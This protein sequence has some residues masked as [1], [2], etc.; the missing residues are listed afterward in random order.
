MSSITFQA[1]KREAFLIRNLMPA[2]CIEIIEK[3]FGKR[4]WKMK[5]STLTRM[6]GEMM[7]TAIDYEPTK[8]IERAVH[9]WI[10]DF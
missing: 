7:K 9:T 10:N 4:A 1:A 5:P 2:D 8:E 3:H 6:I